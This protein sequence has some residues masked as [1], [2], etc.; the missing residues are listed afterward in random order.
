MTIKIVMILGSVRPGRMAERVANLF[1]G[2]FKSLGV[3]PQVLDPAK[4]SPDLT[5]QPLHFLKSPQDDAPKWMLEANETVK[6]ADGF[7]IL[8]PEYNCGIPPA[9]SNIM[10]AL[11]PPSFRHKPCGLVSY[12]VSTFGG[13]RAL[14]VLK[15]FV[16]EVG[17]VP[18]PTYC[19]I[20]NVNS[21]ID[22]SGAAKE[23]MVTDRAKQ[24]IQEVLWYADA[25]RTFRKSR[26][27]PS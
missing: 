14:T 25:L 9:L 23:S 13:M 10:N 19:P 20:P 24:T 1:L 11:P 15:P 6:R 22:E 2:Q 12:S 16:S 17:L 26:P 8:T 21:I 7:L 18:V 27:L 4:I 5:Q 3:T